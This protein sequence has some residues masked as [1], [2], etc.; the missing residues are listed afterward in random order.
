[1]TN[2]LFFVGILVL[3][4]ALYCNSGCS[5]APSR[6]KPPSIDAKAA[7][8][9]AME[10]YDANQD[11]KI[12]GV[13]LEKAPSLKA[14]LANLDNSNDKSVDAD[15]VTKRIEAWHES[16]KGLMSVMTMVT[17]GG[18]PLAGAT[19]VFEPEAFL[20]P[21]IKQATG[22]TNEQGVALMRIEG[23]DSPGVAPGLYL[24]RITNEGMNLP[25]KYNTETILGAEV[26]ADADYTKRNLDGPKFNL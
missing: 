11:G 7:G 20:G 25:T 15:E 9:A 3:A 18:R 12:D 2:R 4:I 19:V 8:A 13:E 14:A 5:R 24:V 21:N 16:K 1:M 23:A 6:V 22:T 17:I 10:Q 26:A